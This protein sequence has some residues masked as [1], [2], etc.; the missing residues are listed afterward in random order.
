MRASARQIVRSWKSHREG[1]VGITLVM[2]RHRACVLATIWLLVLP[3]MLPHLSGCR[4]G[5]P[6]GPRALAEFYVREALRV[7]KTAQ[8]ESSVEGKAFLEARERMVALGNDVLPFL[9]EE[10]LSLS[11]EDRRYLLQDSNAWWSFWPIL[12]PEAGKFL[13]SQLDTLD[14]SEQV[15]AL[16]LIGCC[17]Y[18]E[19]VPRIVELYSALRGGSKHARAMVPSAEDRLEIALLLLRDLSSPLK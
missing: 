8:T 6:R 12:T 15:E 5:P 2:A 17:G 3:L 14:D 7:S 4:K 11:K 10:Y 9:C 18:R 13:Y 19:A 16:L 1:E